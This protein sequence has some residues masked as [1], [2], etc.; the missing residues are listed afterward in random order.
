MIKKYVEDCR[1]EEEEE[2]E[3]GMCRRQKDIFRKSTK[4][5]LMLVLSVNENMPRNMCFV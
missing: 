3:T 1:E 2:E 5:F 4:Q